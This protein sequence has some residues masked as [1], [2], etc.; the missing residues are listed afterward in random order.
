MLCDIDE[1]LSDQAA[2]SGEY[3]DSVK[4]SKVTKTVMYVLVVHIY[5]LHVDRAEGGEEA[6]IQV[7][8]NIGV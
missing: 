2:S 3:L 7:C 5:H 4:C 8:K 6:E 1:S